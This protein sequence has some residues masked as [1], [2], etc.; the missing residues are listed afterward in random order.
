MKMVSTQAE[1]EAMLA[2]ERCL[3]F[4]DAAWSGPARGSKAVVRRLMDAWNKQSPRQPL[5][6]YRVD[7]SEQTGPLWEAV[8]QWMDSQFAPSERL[9]FGGGG[10]LLWLR[11]GVILAHEVYPAGAGSTAHVGTRLA[12][13][14]KVYSPIPE[15][16]LRTRLAFGIGNSATDGRPVDRKD[17]VVLVAVEDAR[18]RHICLLHLQAFGYAPREI[19]PQEL[20][21]IGPTFGPNGEAV[22][23]L[24]AGPD[25]EDMHRIAERL[26]KDW[27][28]RG[29][30]LLV[31]FH[32]TSAWEKDYFRLVGL[33]A[34][35]RFE[36]P[37]Q[38]WTLSRSINDD[39]LPTVSEIVR[40]LPRFTGE[41]QDRDSNG[42]E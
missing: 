6:L 21:T 40:V 7:L 12:S 37:Q 16:I 4:I 17:Y 24:Y 20:L 42:D 30:V 18:L 36:S 22:V 3:L 41:Y 11:S 32:P 25:K 10:S 1:F 34:G 28:E 29:F 19:R 27:S 31:A 26:Y 8:R 2:E 15:L 5:E 35:W 23:I 14:F 38:L 39:F 13:F 33:D 9:M